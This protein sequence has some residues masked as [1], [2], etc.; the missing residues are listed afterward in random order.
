MWRQHDWIYAPHYSVI[1]FLLDSYSEKLLSISDGKY[2][3]FI[4]KNVSMSKLMHPRRGSSGPICPAVVRLLNC[5]INVFPSRGLLHVGRGMF[6][7]WSESF[8]IGKLLAVARNWS[9]SQFWVYSLQSAFLANNSIRIRVIK[10]V[11]EWSYF[12]FK[13]FYYLNNVIAGQ[14]YIPP[15]QPWTIPSISYLNWLVECRYLGIF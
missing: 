4:I 15:G 1:R 13:L 7:V 2:S 14:V 6:V 8:A 11:F 3:V 12:V 9:F 10:L 5:L